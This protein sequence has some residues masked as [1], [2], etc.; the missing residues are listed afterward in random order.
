MLTVYGYTK[1]STCRKAVKWLDGCGVAYKFID[2]T[3]TPP[4]KAVLRRALDSGHTLKQLFNTSGEL[5]RSMNIKDR[6]PELAPE[7]ALALLAECG[8]LCRR[9]I[10]TDGRKATAGFDVEMFERCWN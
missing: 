9:P 5:Y 8:R 10:V 4:P 2:I 6:L 1:C 7:D 3:R